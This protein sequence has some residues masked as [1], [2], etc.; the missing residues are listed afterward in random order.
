MAENIENNIPGEVGETDYVQDNKQDKRISLAQSLSAYR[1]IST[2][3]SL[4]WKQN[5]VNEKF[6]NDNILLCT[7][8]EKQRF[9]ERLQFHL[10]IANNI[11]QQGGTVMNGADFINILTSK[12][13]ESIKKTDRQ[14]VFS[15]SNGERP[16]GKKAYLLWNGWQVIDMDIKDREIAGKLKEYIFNDLKKYLI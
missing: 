5:Y 8:E 4:T 16:V 11:R 2:D 9:S 13:F 7:D 6:S 3:K 14:V 1:C 15:T 10:T 12:K